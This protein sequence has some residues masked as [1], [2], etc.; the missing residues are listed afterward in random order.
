MRLSA[1]QLRER[2]AL[3]REQYARC[4]LC[5]HHCGV[6]RTKGPAGICAE[7]DSLWLAGA[8]VHFGADPG[9]DRES[10]RLN[11]SHLVISYAD[12]CLEKKNAHSRPNDRESLGKRI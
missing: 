11:S 5:G 12:F 9:G 2:A 3:A 4:H 7:G 1:S 6:D 8:G 10:T